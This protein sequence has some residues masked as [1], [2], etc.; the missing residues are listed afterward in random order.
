MKDGKRKTK[1]EKHGGSGGREGRGGRRLQHQHLQHLRHGVLLV[2]LLSSSVFLFQA[3]GKKGPPLAPLNLAPEMPQQATA[4]R[5]GDTVYIQMHV[6]AKN[7]TGRGAYSVD[8]LEVYAITTA[9]GGALPK[10]IDLVKPAQLV[11]K[12]GVRPPPDPD[13]P[14]PDETEQKKETRPLPGDAVTFREK[15]DAAH[16]VPH[17]LPTKKVNQPKAPAVKGAEATAASA[18]DSP[19]PPGGEGGPVAPAT[20]TVLTRSYVIRGV[21]RNGNVGTPTVRIDVPLLAAPGPPRAGAAPSW[22]ESSVTINWSPPAAATDEAPGVLYNVYPHVASTEPDAV[23]MAVPPPLPLNPKPVEETSFTHAGAEPEKEQ[24]FVVRSVAAVGTSTIES[25]ASNPIC[26]TPKDTFPPAA[27][28]A[29]TAV[30]DTGAVN[31]VWDANTESDLA[32][33]LVL[34]AEA[35]GDN[36][37]PL[38]RDLIKENR[39]IDRTAQPGVAYFYTVIAVDK[40]GNRSTPS[41]RVQET[42]R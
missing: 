24:C 8:R 20:P 33:Y 14:E 1:D 2:F 42:A 15:L 35:P 22:D 32:G 30:G 16:L 39:Y 11:T 12:I 13:A 23:G 6:P 40:A 29:L 37:Q 3:C 10:N 7:A 28:K 5:L 4:R 19:R 41:N 38:M 25:D 34:R 21:A 9:A 18:T 31:L 17:S 27:P 36:M 26:V